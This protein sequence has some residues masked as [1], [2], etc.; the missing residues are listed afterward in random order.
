M[1]GVGDGADPEVG[2]GARAGA[3][4]HRG[5]VRHDLVDEAGA[6][7][8]A[9]ERGPALEEDVLAVAG[10]EARQRL[11]RVAGAQVH[12]LG[13]VVEDAPVG[14]EVAQSHDRAQRL[15]G[16]RLVDLVTDREL[17]VVD[18][19][20]GGADEHRVAEAAQAVG[21]EARG[22]AGHPAA[23]A[24]GG[25]AAAVE[26]RGELPGDE[27]PLVL[28][29]EAPRTVDGAR[30]VGELAA[31]HVDAGLAQAPRA[32]LGDRVGVGLR[33]DDTAYA[34]S[35][36]CLAARTGAAGVVA[37]LEGDHGGRAAS[38]VTG[39]RERGGLGVRGAGAAVEALRDRRPVRG[40]QH[41][42]DARVGTERDAGRD[43]ERQGA[44]HG[45]ALCLAGRHLR[46]RSGWCG[47][48]GGRRRSTPPQIGDAYEPSAC[49]SHPDCDRRSRSSTWSTGHWMWSGRGL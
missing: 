14:R 27:R 18:L 42:A 37:R 13:A 30:L 46:L 36:Q 34:G 41:A 40:E 32:A 22:T 15:H 25:G 38:R 1:E 7:E 29:R 8:G 45:A 44:P 11:L 28:D 23:G 12:G 39:L 47:L 48:S 31:D 43:G 2:D 49:T 33:E 19:D 10:E 17:R 26:G 24:V 4:Q 3:E 5:D 16:D 35:D 9:R 21:V 20:G 6:E